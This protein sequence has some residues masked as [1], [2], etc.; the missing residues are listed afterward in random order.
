MAQRIDTWIFDLDNTLYPARCNLFAQVDRR[1]GEY[2]ARF[3]GISYDQAKVLQKQYWREH[4]TSLRGMMVNHACPPD[5]FLDYV[6]AID[7]SA[8]PHSAA[9]DAALARLPGRKLIFTNGT[10]AHAARV[11]DRLGVTRH[12]DHVFDIVASEY[13]PKPD[14]GVFRRFVERLHIDPAHA[15]MLED[16]AHNLEPAHRMGMQTVW[17]RTEESVARHAQAGGATAHI[18][19]QTEDLVEWL[20]HYL[21]GT[22]PRT[23]LSG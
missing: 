7:V 18:H 1:I 23:S 10:V 13:I 9:L 21:Q 17:V 11:M 2:M 4:G 16:M 22:L 12:F 6:H 20:E 5:D 8:V 15:I 19:H 14:E 3:L